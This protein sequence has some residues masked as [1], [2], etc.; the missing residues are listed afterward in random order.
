MKHLH[1]IM[2][3]FL[4]TRYPRVYPVK[5]YTV[6]ARGGKRFSPNFKICA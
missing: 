6:W 1:F 2:L 5:K 4:R 3:S